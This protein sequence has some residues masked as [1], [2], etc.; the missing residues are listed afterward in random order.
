MHAWLKRNWVG[1]AVIVAVIASPVIAHNV[2]EQSANEACHAANEV[3]EESNARVDE[4]Q[5]L[6]GVVNSFLDAAKT[7]RESSYA[8][9]GDP[10]DKKAAEAYGRQLE[11]LAGVTFK[12]VAA[13]DC[14][15]VGS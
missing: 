6:K 10:A 7:A 5:E 12:K 13:S 1:L 3:R 2:A 9:G 15:T 4:I 14:G 8:T 11:K